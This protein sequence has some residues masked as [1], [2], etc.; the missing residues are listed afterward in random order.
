MDTGVTTIRNEADML[1][2]TLSDINKLASSGLSI[3]MDGKTVRELIQKKQLEDSFRQEFEGTLAHR[4]ER[5]LQVKPHEIVPNTHFA[6]VSAEC[7]LLF[8]DR[9][10]YACIALT[11]AVAEA[12]VRFLCERNSWKP[13][14]KFEKNIERL[15]KR[16]FISDE[17]RESFLG[18][19]NDRDDYHHLN[20]NVE[21]DR[22]VLE[23]LAREKARI[24]VEVESEIF[25]FTITD[26]KII[27]KYSKY[28]D[29]IGNQAQV[30]ARFEP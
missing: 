11:Q 21:A 15:Y 19:W 5:Y 23:E 30:F 12:L 6:A 1:Y 3:R 13:D 27:P 26:G 10:F 17:L 16:N 29:I 25:S 22:Q 14:N 4:V 28:W 8:R 9:H 20:S 7:A 24:L 2:Q 18:I